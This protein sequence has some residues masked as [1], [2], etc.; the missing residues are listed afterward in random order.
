MKILSQLCFYFVG[1][2]DVFFITSKLRYLY[3]QYSYVLLMTLG[4]RYI[5]V[6]LNY[7]QMLHLKNVIFKLRLFVTKN[8]EKLRN[9]YIVY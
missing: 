3:V 8:D 2:C 6:R 7:V 9:Y 5:L 4:L 1:H